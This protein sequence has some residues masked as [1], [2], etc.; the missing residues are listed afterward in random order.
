[1]KSGDY[2]IHVLIEKM[3][4]IDA[5][6]ASI[7]A[8]VHL[9]TCGLRHYSSVKNG[10]RTDVENHRVIW[11]EHVYFEAKNVEGS[12]L[13]EQ[14]LTIK[15]I[16]QDICWNTLIAE[17]QFDLATIYRRN[18][19]HS[20]HNQWVA[21]NMPSSAEYEKIR[22]LLQVSVAIQGPGD[23]SV[24]LEEAQGFESP[25][26]Y[27]VIMPPSVTREYKQFTIGVLTAQNLPGMDDVVFLND[28]CDLNAFVRLK[29]MGKRLRTKTFDRKASAKDKSC[30]FN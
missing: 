29:W 10:V 1:M 13:E 20:I 5:G 4:K 22:A 27:K 6:E 19:E 23:S 18:E 26:D 30:T 11:N 15:L 9:E 24:K 7:D 14:Q 21:M 3:E 25:E 8:M 28:F 16:N 17:F 2:M 12:Y